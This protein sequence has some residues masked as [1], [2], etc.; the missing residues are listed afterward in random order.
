MKRKYEKCEICGK[1]HQYRIKETIEYKGELI[2]VETLKSPC[3]DEI[4]RLAV[5]AVN[6]TIRKG[7]MKDEKSC[8][9]FIH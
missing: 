5:G 3:L 7:V 8:Y 6:Q 4:A 9:R 1:R 2:E